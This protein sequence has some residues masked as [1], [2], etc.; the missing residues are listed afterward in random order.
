MPLTSTKFPNGCLALCRSWAGQ[1]AEA[2]TSTRNSQC[3]TV[4]PGEI[5]ALQ[6]RGIHLIRL[7]PRRMESRLLLHHSA[8]VAG[9][10]ARRLVPV[11]TQFDQD[12]PLLIHGTFTRLIGAALLSELSSLEEPGCS[13]LLQPAGCSV[14][15]CRIRPDKVGAPTNRSNKNRR[16]SNRWQ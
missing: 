10:S 15:D 4:V 16:C 1:H 3:L 2:V 13:E 6:Q 14:Q 7:M 8:P 5:W 12:W 9:A 11:R